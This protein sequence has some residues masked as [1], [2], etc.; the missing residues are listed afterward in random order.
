M[1][2]P[3]KQEID[4][5]FTGN[6]AR[7]RGLVSLYSTLVGSSGAGRPS[8]EHAD[9]LRAAVILAHAAIED[10]LRST[11]E[12]RLPNALPEAL[13]GLRLAPP[14]GTLKDAKEKFTFV[15][16]SAY[17]GQSVDEVIERAIG[18]YLEKS[19]YN[20]IAEVKQALQRAGVAHTFSPAEAATIEAMMKRRHWIAHRADR[21][22]LIGPGHHAVQPIGRDVVDGWISV[23]ESFGKSVLVNL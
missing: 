19:N 21:N 11:E 7:V 22:T 5:R 2:P 13:L 20:N 14:H 12:L 10:L 3:T 17:R 16:L 1:A 15:E 9:V 8:V 4:D 6:V 23:I 18:L